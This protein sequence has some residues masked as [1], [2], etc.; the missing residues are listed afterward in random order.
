MHDRLARTS[1]DDIVIDMIYTRG[2]PEEPTEGYTEAGWG[3]WRGRG[4]E[5]GARA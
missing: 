3:I 4:G 1:I 2:P 5:R